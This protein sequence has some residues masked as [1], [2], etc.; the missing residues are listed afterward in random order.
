MLF[1]GTDVG[2]LTAQAVILEDEKILG[3]NNIGVLPNPVESA[4]KV[5]EELLERLGL[6]KDGII[7][8]STGYGREKLVEVGF[9]IEHISEISCHAKGAFWLNKAVRTVIDI[10]GQDAKVIRVDGNGRLVNFVMNDKCA[11][12]TGRFLE[13]Q[14]RALGVRLEDLG[15]LTFL[16]KN[17]VEITA[18][19][20]IFAETEVLHFLQRGFPK[21]EIA[22][23]VNKSMAQRIY[24][25]AKRVGVEREVA[26]TGGVAKNRGVKWELEKILKVK[27][28]DLGIDPQIVGALGAAI[29]AKEK[30]GGV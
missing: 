12:G 7:V 26:L 11:A 19:C 1:A 28:V 4:K 17:P 9:A 30:F 29:F 20:S 6:K 21:E 18:R 27:F 22:A 3:W 8:F 13:I 23:G 2:S 16:A 5:M 14:A 15:E 24:Y 25:L 10:G